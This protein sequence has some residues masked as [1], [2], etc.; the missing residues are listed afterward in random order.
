MPHSGL[1]RRIKDSAAGENVDSTAGADA[2]AIAM[3]AVANAALVNSQ[4]AAMRMNNAIV[5]AKND[6]ITFATSLAD[7]L[8]QGKSLMDDLAAAATSMGKKLVDTGLTSLLNQGLN[9]LTGGGTGVTSSVAS[10]AALSAGGTSAAAAIAAACTAGGAAL[11]AGGTAAAGAMVGA[12]SVGGSQLS[13]AGE[14]AGVGIDV[15]T[16]VGGA[17]LVTSGATAGGFIATAAAALGIS[18][19]TL[20]AVMGPLAA[21]AAAAVGVGTVLF[22]KQ[23]VSTT[24]VK[25]V[26]NVCNNHS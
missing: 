12:T 6:G 11:A 2:L 18:A 22:A 17:Q 20:A 16:S 9:A 1:V 24:E 23:E 13:T 8:L 4:A 15:G 26:K 5:D 19:D 3:V 10:G 21:V 14:V 25:E 7:G